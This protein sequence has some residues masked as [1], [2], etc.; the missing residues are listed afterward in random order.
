M[1]WC[2]CLSDHKQ[3]VM[4]KCKIKWEIWPTK[5]G[6]ANSVFAIFE[7][8]GSVMGWFACVYLYNPTCLRMK[9]NQIKV[10]Y[11]NEFLF[12]LIMITEWIWSV[13]RAALGQ[14]FDFPWYPKL[15]SGPPV[16]CLTAF[17]ASLFEA[18]MSKTTVAALEVQT[19][20]RRY[21]RPR[22]DYL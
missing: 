6:H 21:G 5:L 2:Q 19:G 10:K 9:S 4:I 14:N 8:D 11:T 1:C 13:S 18:L 20:S 12:D 16:K 17:C 22:S 7:V 15:C 3:S